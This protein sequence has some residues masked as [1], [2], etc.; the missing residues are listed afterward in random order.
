MRLINDSNAAPMSVIPML[1]SI[2]RE[3]LERS[4]AIFTLEGQ[5]ASPESL[6]QPRTETD[7]QLV[8]SL[9][10]QKREMV[11]SAKELDKLGWE[12]DTKQPMQFRS[13]GETGKEAYVWKPEDS[14]FFRSA[15]I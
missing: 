7:Y 8:A 3:L 9:A 11:R 15:E 4:H 13:K 10:N 6:K 14:F 5:A 12:R 1:R 2:A